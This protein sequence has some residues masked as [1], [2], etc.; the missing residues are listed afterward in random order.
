MRTGVGVGR[1]Q[2]QRG[3]SICEPADVREAPQMRGFGEMAM[4]A[5]LGKDAVMRPPSGEEETSAPVPKSAKENKRKR[6]STSEDP[7][8]KTRTARFSFS[9]GGIFQFLGRAEPTGQKGEEIKDLRAELAKAH[10]DQTD[11]IEKAK[12]LEAD[13]GALDSDDD[14][15]DSESGSKREEEPDGEETGPEDN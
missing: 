9:S 7:K 11:L 5:G 14:D 6:A 2:V 4:Y 3:M 8:L 12:E 15:D 13:A 1:T 10:Q